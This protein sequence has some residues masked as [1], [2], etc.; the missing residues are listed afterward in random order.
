MFRGY[1]N[2]VWSIGRAAFACL[3]LTAFFAAAAEVREYSIDLPENAPSNV[4]L[5][6]RELSYYAGKITGQE[7][8]FEGTG[9]K[10][11]LRL[12]SSQKELL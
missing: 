6:A 3:A 12:D 7:L 1:R 10:I 8:P 11:T 9:K 2:T 5:A 4:R